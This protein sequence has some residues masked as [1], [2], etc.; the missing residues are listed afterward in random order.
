M[1]TVTD[2]QAAVTDII[3]GEL[4][5]ATTK[6]YHGVPVWCVGDEPTIG[7]KPAKAHVSV[8]FFRG[9]R[10]ADGTGALVAS[11]SFEMASVKL[12]GLADL[13]EDALRTWV[14]AAKELA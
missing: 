14:R 7:V 2:L 1:S 6:V 4:P 11:G 3:D 13:D 5:E 10:I 8:L 12:A 9:Q